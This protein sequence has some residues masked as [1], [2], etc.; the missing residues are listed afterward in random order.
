MRESATAGV[1]AKYARRRG[2]WPRHSPAKALGAPLVGFSGSFPARRARLTASGPPE[3]TKDGAA[4][5][6]VDLDG[7]SLKAIDK[8]AE[9]YGEGNPVHFQNGRAEFIPPE[10]P[11][12]TDRQQ[13]D[14]SREVYE[15]VIAESPVQGASA[16]WQDVRH[17][18]GAATGQGVMRFILALL[19]MSGTAMAQVQNRTYQ[20]SMGRNIGRSVTDARGNTTFYDSM[21]R[22]TGRSVTDS[23]G[24]TAFYD[25]MGRNTGRS[26]TNG[27]TTTTY[28]NFGRRTGSIQKSR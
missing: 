13:R 6:V 12:G 3:S 2:H 17:R 28:D 27:N 5:Y 15:R 9:R 10:V 8:G 18:W 14:S 7:S 25:S 1:F 26:T 11:S 19:V 24:N 23:R 20:D 4:V 22:N 16:I 21:G